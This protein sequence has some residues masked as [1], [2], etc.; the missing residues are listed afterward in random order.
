MQRA[1]GKL[2]EPQTVV[3]L[4]WNPPESANCSSSVL[5][6]PLWTNHAMA[7]L[8]PTYVGMLPQQSPKEREGYFGPSYW[9][10][11]RDYLSSAIVCRRFTWNRENPCAAACRPP[12][13][14]QH[15]LVCAL[16]CR[17]EALL[18][19]VSCQSQLARSVRFPSLKMPITR[20]PHEVL[21]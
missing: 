3:G 14:L 12:W 5:Q 15:S 4:L 6:C 21:S 18:E 10:N 7:Q 19:R 9:G 8:D 13:S 16:R 1:I 2:N 17:R 20:P 11:T